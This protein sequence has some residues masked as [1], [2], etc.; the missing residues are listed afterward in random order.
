MDTN[1][2]S[3]MFHLGDIL[4][5]T[6]GKLVSPTNMDGV[7]KILNFMTGDDLMTHQ[8]GRVTTICAPHLAGAYPELLDIVLPKVTK[9]NLSSVLAGLA[10]QYGEYLEVHKLPEGAYVRLNALE[11]LVTMH[12]ASK[13]E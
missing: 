8:L 4:S 2:N 6:T 9:E 13:G 12:N 3:R 5:I 11:E 7:Y 10:Q 1:E